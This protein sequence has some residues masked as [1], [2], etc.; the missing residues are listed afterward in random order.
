M[1]SMKNYDKKPDKSNQEVIDKFIEIT[2]MQQ[3]EDM[4][5]T[6]L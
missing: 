3:K 5:Q 2:T 1:S 6:T 4:S